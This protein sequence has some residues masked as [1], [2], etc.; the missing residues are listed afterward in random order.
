MRRTCYSWIRTLPLVWGLALAKGLTKGQIYI[1]VAVRCAVRCAVWCAVRCAVQLRPFLLKIHI[2]F[3]VLGYERTE[4]VGQNLSIS[5]AFLVNTM[6]PKANSHPLRLLLLFAIGQIFF[7][8]GT[9]FAW[10]WK[11]INPLLKFE[12]KWKQTADQK[13]KVVTYRPHIVLQET[14]EE[15]R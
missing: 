9:R 14:K 7:L 8:N 1:A 6:T 2:F 12:M 15:Q 5:P 11:K 10:G 13:S 4:L 3:P